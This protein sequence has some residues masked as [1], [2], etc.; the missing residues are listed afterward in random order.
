MSTNKKIPAIHDKYSN[1]PEEVKVVMDDEE[2]AEQTG[3]RST[4]EIVESMMLAGQRLEDYRAGLLDQM[5]EEDDNQLMISPY[6]QDPVDIEKN[7]YM[8]RQKR[9]RLEA[10]LKAKANPPEADKNKP[11]VEKKTS[12]SASDKA[13]DASEGTA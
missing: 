6:E 3:Y 7:V 12:E 5:D 8:Q 4:K 9:L 13:P 1:P 2:I 10:E 11:T